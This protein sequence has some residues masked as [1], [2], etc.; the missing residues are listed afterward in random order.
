MLG[1]GCASGP[2]RAEQAALA[3]VSAPLI[4]QSVERATGKLLTESLQCNIMPWLA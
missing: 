3:A 1:I 4:Q 2:D